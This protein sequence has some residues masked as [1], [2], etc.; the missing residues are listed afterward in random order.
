MIS[1]YA[2]RYKTD[3]DFSLIGGNEAELQ[4]EIVLV[5]YL[6]E[7]LWV[8]PQRDINNLKSMMSLFCS[9]LRV[10][11]FLIQCQDPNQYYDVNDYGSL[12]KLLLKSCMYLPFR[13]LKLSLRLSF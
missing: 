10:S 12:Y 7:K 8:H 4:H 5:I 1:S 11:Y 9:A 2:S 3:T 6:F 13:K